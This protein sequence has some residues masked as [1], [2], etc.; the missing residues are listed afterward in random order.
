MA[1]PHGNV[2]DRC[3]LCLTGDWRTWKPLRLYRY[4]VCR[5]C[6]RGFALRRQLAFVVDLL[7]L[8]VVGF[9]LELVAS[10]IESAL[11]VGPAPTMTTAEVIA[12]LVGL[13]LFAL[14]DGFA[15]HSPGKAHARLQVVATDTL[16]PIG[17]GRSF[18]R[19]VPFLLIT[20]AALAVAESLGRQ[21]SVAGLAWALLMAVMT[22]QMYRGPR[23]GDG[24]ARTK[25]IRK[26]F[27]FRPPFDTRGLLC[28]NC[29]Y[30]L[31]GSVSSVCSEC[32]YP[33]RPPSTPPVTVS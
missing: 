14:K 11:G 16:E 24:L 28:T 18:L 22:I 3:P 6:Y 21:G 1:D 12:L 5:S 33:I 13:V 9:L 2:E 26:I 23:W 19:N 30:D 7:C 17:F 4:R 15:G 25:V 32:G 27:R 29:G 31:R 20:G 10:R 8:W